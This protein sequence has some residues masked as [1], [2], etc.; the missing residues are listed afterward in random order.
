MTY[1]AHDVG[2]ITVVINGI[3]HCFAI[4][5]QAFILLTID[6]VPALKGLVQMQGIHANKQIA[7]NIQARDAI[8]TIAVTAAK[9]L[10]CLLAEAFSPIED[11]LIAPHPT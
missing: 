7:D 3:A 10:P 6:L 11:G 2:L 8:T 5:G 1:H 9:S 4:N